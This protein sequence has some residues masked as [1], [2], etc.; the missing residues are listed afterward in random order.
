[1]TAEATRNYS[2]LVAERDLD[3][4]I[5]CS[6]SRQHQAPPAPGKLARVLGL[7][8]VAGNRAVTALLQRAPP[9]TA[10]TPAP[11]GPAGPQAPS[12]QATASTHTSRPTPASI[13]DALAHIKLT[14]TTTTVNQLEPW[15]IFRLVPANTPTKK[16][17]YGELR[18]AWVDLKAAQKK[19]ADADA[20]LAQ[21]PAS[22]P[23]AAPATPAPAT[24]KPHGKPP[25]Q[26]DHRAQ[27]AAAAAAVDR[28]QARVETVTEAIKQFIVDSDPTVRKVNADERSV[29]RSLPPKRAALAALKARKKPDDEKV[30]A[31]ELAIA[32][33][34]QD[35]AAIPDRRQKAVDAVKAKIAT[36][37]FSPQAI[38]RTIYNFEIDGGSV[39]LSD[40]VESWA[41]MFE[42]GLVEADRAVHATLDDVLAKTS[43][44]E[45]NKKILGAISDNE[46]AGAPWSS[47]NTY[48]RAVLTWGLV[49]WTGGSHSDLTAAL[50][51]IK[52]VAP[53]AFADRF[54]KYGIDVIDDELVITG[55]DGSTVKG[56]AAARAIM[57]S[58]QLSAVM[59]RAG[60][61]ANIEQ[62]EVVAAAQQQ[63]IRPLAGTFTVDAPKADGPTAKA[64]A[65]PE[66]V[67]LRYSD[68][69]TSE[70][71]VGL[72]AD[73]V[74]NS[75]LGRA[76]QTVAAAVRA[77]LATK[78][79]DPHGVSS[80]AG[81]FE[82]T[83]LDAL[84]PFKNRAVPFEKRG[85]SKKAGSYS[86]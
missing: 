12:T 55:A 70:Y 67:R 38:E 30:R 15:E 21:A 43:L 33:L 69:L 41:T 40:R 29:K 13:A 61:D 7:Q 74:V 9:E 46:S 26:V 45:S 3:A 79:V 19:L 2:C 39:T 53:D 25:K 80:W 1:L 24:R 72:F 22:Q 4:R 56:S 37:P 86:G 31:T 78:H 64:K 6:P 83:V 85:A 17:L 59:A 71:A 34:E 23:A 54:E 66:R 82:T 16:K 35:L 81:D 63:I 27:R 58:P 68:V 73:Q 14:K 51:T 57:Q 10:V 77:Y 36:T 48:D 11:S 50:T 8:R 62:A 84:S 65:K 52:S 20:A 18:R 60:Q 47:V 32:S 42:N 28:A 49:Q 76:Q 75:G 5:V 44:S